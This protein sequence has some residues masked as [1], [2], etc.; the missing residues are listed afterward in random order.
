MDDIQ[1]WAELALISDVTY[2]PESMATYRVLVES[3]S[4]SKSLL[5]VLKFWQSDAEMRL[6]LFDKYNLSKNIRQKLELEW[7]NRS[8]VLAFHERNANLADEVRKIKKR[9]TSK[10]WLRYYGAKS[11]A[12][13]SIYRATAFLL[14]LFRNKAD[15]HFREFADAPRELC[16]L[17]I[18][19]NADG[20]A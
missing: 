20:E 3:A 7:C 4:R 10:D 18:D 17:P 6:Y 12:V 15:K 11:F 13:H 14:H 5:K 1:I 8:L 2:I 16:R 19:N 9:F